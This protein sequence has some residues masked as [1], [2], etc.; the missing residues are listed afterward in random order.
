M[1]RIIITIV[2]YFLRITECQWVQIWYDNMDTN[3]GWSTTNDA[4]LAQTY[5]CFDGRCARTRVYD[6]YDSY[7]ERTTND[8]GEYTD[9]RIQLDLVADGLEYYDKCQIRYYWNPAW[10][11][12]TT[13]LGREFDDGVYDNATYTFPSI[14]NPSSI[15]IRL[16]VHGDSEEGGDR[17]YW[18]NVYLEGYR[19]T[20]LSPTSDPTIIPTNIPS[21]NPT[22]DPTHDP[23][24]DPTFAPTLYPS[25]NPTSHPT[26]NPTIEPSMDPTV[27]P[28]IRPTERPTNS[29]SDGDES[30][31]IQNSVLF[32]W[33]ILWSNHRLHV[34][35]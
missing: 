9:I 6:E 30:E 28:T 34:C 1:D 18:D 20:T 22:T 11:S 33:L 19:P 25:V 7:I 32:F 2:C 4:T 31:A 21:N 24:T 8:I 12:T 14:P 27:H 35:V 15:R 26:S 13:T 3:S 5:N 17:C 29:P 16:K 23:S 10:W